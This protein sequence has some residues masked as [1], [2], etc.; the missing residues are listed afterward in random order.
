MASEVCAEK[1]K[2]KN[3]RRKTMELVEYDVL[4]KINKEDIH[5]VNYIIEGEDNV[6]NIRSVEGEFLKIITPKDFLVDTIV[7]LNS[8]KEFINLEIYEIR[9]NSGKAD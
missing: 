4:V 7:L 8:L 5:L 3:E 2:L 1:K 6:M 9:Q